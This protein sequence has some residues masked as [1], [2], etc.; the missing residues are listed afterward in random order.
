MRS[1]VENEVHEPSAETP[2]R[3]AS[4]VAPH[5]PVASTNSPRVSFHS[6][7]VGT[8]VVKGAK[9]QATVL[10]HFK[11][12]IRYYEIWN[13]QN[14]SREWEGAPLNAADYV[15]LLEGAYLAI[16]AV[17]PQ[18]IVVS[19]AVEV[20]SGECTLCFECTEVCPEGHALELK[21]KGLGA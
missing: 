17:D 2:P 16:K 6:L 5:A 1:R 7:T 4:P 14:L 10:N 9:V 20:R 8:P 15:R 11:G 21:L 3:T 19:R 18:A 12:R 13:E